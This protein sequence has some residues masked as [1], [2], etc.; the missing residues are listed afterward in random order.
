MRC[1]K[2]KRIY[3][4]LLIFISLFELN[5]LIAVANQIYP[6]KFHF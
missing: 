6:L 4:K 3:E 2:N 5:N 1:L